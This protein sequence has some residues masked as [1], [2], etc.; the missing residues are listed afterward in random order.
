[1]WP[2]NLELRV[3]PLLRV[4]T[5]GPCVRV[6]PPPPTGPPVCHQGQPAGATW[7]R[8]IHGHFAQRLTFQTIFRFVQH[9]GV[10]LVP[11][12]VSAAGEAAPATGLS[13]GMAAAR[14][15]LTGAHTSAR[16]DGKARHIAHAAF[17]DAHG[18][19]GRH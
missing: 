16:G 12:G 17:P 4:N 9:R 8:A 6:N 1:M 14:P 13:V 15:E 19:Q 3:V 5:W 11:R 2:L 18:A 7:T 10:M